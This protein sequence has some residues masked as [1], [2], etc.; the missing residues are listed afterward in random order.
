MKYVDFEEKISRPKRI[1]LIGWPSNIP[2]NCPSILLRQEVITLINLATSKP[3]ALRFKK[4][5][6][7]QYSHYLESGGRNCGKEVD[8]LIIENG[9]NDIGP[10]GDKRKPDANHSKAK[11][12][13]RK[14]NDGRSNNRVTVHEGDE[15][16]SPPRDF[17]FAV[18]A[19]SNNPNHQNNV[20]SALPYDHLQPY[21]PSSAP[22]YIPPLPETDETSDLSPMSRVLGGRF[23]DSMFPIFSATGSGPLF[24]GANTLPSVRSTSE[25]FP[26]NPNQ[27]VYD[28]NLPRSD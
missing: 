19:H 27:E 1:V 7:A 13:K 2:L 4:L 10:P 9:G 3:P 8:D 11:S 25:T 23:D 16:F 12:K 20:T 24:S 26:S 14:T 15:N 5:S 17:E 22:N 21:L 18:S 28:F 6:H